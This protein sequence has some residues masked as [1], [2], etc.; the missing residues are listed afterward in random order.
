MAVAVQQPSLLEISDNAIFL[1]HKSSEEITIDFEYDEFEDITYVASGGYG[2]VFH[3][4]WKRTGEKVALKRITNRLDER[5]KR[6]FRRELNAMKNV[7]VKKNPYVIQFFGLTRDPCDNYVMIMQYANGGN[8]REYL[9][10]NH[11]SM[12]WDER[13]NLAIGIVE[14]LE[15][16]HRH[17]ILHR[18]LN[19]LIHDGKPILCDFGLSKSYDDTD[20]SHGVY[21]VIPYIDPLRY[22]GHA[23]GEASEVYGIGVLLWEISS[24]RVPFSDRTTDPQSLIGSIIRGERENPIS[25]TPIDYANL[26]EDCWSSCAQ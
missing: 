4:H 6:E 2:D 22:D 16:V 25:G 11:E 8:P 14:A 18:D 7:C 12:T 1:N 3:A 20:S 26:Y 5:R 23:Y 15:F 10:A 21:G 13:I 19:V 9:K 17:G 24:G